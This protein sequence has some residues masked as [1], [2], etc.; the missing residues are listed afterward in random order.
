[1]ADSIEVRLRPALGHRE[2]VR[3]SLR[4]ADPPWFQGETRDTHPV[5]LV[6]GGKTLW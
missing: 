6:T 1:M 5:L 2:A 3:G 4:A